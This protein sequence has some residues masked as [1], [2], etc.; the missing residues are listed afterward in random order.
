MLKKILLLVCCLLLTSCVQQKVEETK[1]REHI[2]TVLKQ[3]QSGVNALN[4]NLLYSI[5]SESFTEHELGREDYVRKM[6][7]MTLL[8]D[9]IAYTNIRV[10]N[11]KIFADV[12]ITGTQLIK[13]RVTIP[14]YTEQLPFMNGTTT[15]QTTF[16]FIYEQAELKLYAEEKQSVSTV[17]LWGEAPPNIKLQ[18]LP[19][20]LA[21]GKTIDVAGDVQKGQNNDVVFVV[22]NNKLIGSAALNGL[23][24]EE[25]SLPLT[26]PST[27][28][29]LYELSVMAFA[30]TLDLNNPSDAILQ[31]AQVIKYSIPIH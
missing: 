11:Y 17:A 31:G 5:I 2:G 30:G 27:A 19:T 4:K 6:L 22:L 29:G 24:G 26:V 21:P 14:L 10:E 8:I 3:Y 7:T 20:N 15:I 23:Q 12:T 28:N 13:P 16:C 9:K 1:L 25:F 18:P